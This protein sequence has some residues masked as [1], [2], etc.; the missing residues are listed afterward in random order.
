MNRFAVRRES[1]LTAFEATHSRPY[2]GHISVFGLPCWGYLTGTTNRA[3]PRWALGL[4]VGKDTLAD[5]SI[6][7]AEGGVMRIR[8]AKR[9]PYLDTAQKT[10]LWKN[11]V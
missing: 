1:G 4:R 8:S 11:L 10:D 9:V 5:E 6:L 3:G 7:I 2:K